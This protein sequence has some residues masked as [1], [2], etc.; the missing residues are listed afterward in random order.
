MSPTS[1]AATP[2]RPAG[3]ACFGRD[4]RHESLGCPWDAVH[5]CLLRLLASQ[6]H[7]VVPGSQSLLLRVAD[8]WQP[9][10]IANAG[11]WTS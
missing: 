5:D 7:A 8:L 9:L 3:L 11:N 1:V 4:I 10:G 2:L 6:L